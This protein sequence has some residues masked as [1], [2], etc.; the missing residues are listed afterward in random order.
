MITDEYRY[1]ILKALEQNPEINQRELAQKLGISLGKTNYCLRALVEVG[2]LKATNFRT[3][4]NKLGY[5]YLLTPKGIEEKV[6]ITSRFLKSKTQ[7]YENLCL[8]IEHLRRDFKDLNR[9]S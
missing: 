1:K 5:M 8:E 6:V 4:K 2:I 3:N 9:A 7:E